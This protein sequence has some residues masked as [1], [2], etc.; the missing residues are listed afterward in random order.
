MYLKYDSDNMNY[1]EKE[2]DG[3]TLLFFFKTLKNNLMSKRYIFLHYLF[4][5]MLRKRLIFVFVFPPFF[6]IMFYE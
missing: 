5:R 4:I 6:Q 2:L 3:Q 1:M